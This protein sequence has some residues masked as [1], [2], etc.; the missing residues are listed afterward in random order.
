MKIVLSVVA[1]A[2]LA[3]NDA[4]IGAALGVLAA[5]W[6][7]IETEEGPPVIPLALT[8]QWFQVTA[9]LF[10]VAF[11]GRSLEATVRSDYRPMVWIGLGCVTA[12]LL[13][14][15]FGIRL[16]RRL[17]PVEGLRPEYAL[18]FKTLTLV[19]FVGTAVIGAVQR[20][21]WEIPSLTQP[22]IAL[23]YLRLGLLYLILRT[24]VRSSRW[25]LVAALLAL[26]IVLGITGFY[27]GFREPL[28]MAALA[29]L[30]I[31]DRR[32]V[33]H[34]MTAAALGTCMVALGVV[35]V[36]VRGDY[37]ERFLADET[38]ANS[39]SARIDNLSSAMRGWASR[40]SF[41]LGQD[42]DKFV[43]RMWA[44]Y[45]PAL[46][47]ARVPSTIPHT[48]GELMRNALIHVVMPRI[49]F[50]SKAS[51][52]SDSELVRRYAGVF[53]AGEQQ[54][55]SIAFGYAAESYVDFGVP[56]MFV[57]VLIYGV[58][59]GAAYAMLL[60]VLRHRDLAI[61]IVTVTFWLTLYLFERS[62][63]KTI[64]LAGTMMIYGGGIGIILDRLW[65]EK[66]RALHPLADEPADA[67]AQW[68]DRIA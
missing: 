4:L 57:P 9:G 43:E 3:S 19:Y 27:A 40:E 24:L 35:W 28:I 29:L 25:P 58:L 17:R 16:I 11:T 68:Q 52:E 47:L 53:V 51:L 63:V 14:I 45:Y 30:E 39:R 56:M 6:I 64:G 41:E 20:L 67:A 60:R 42:V 5:I 54:G 8:L 44:I 48:G 21:A 36:S 7:F 12:L 31:F 2:W 33:R 66:Y 38:F 62:W 65:Y 1:A 49:F 37:R 15:V 59:M 22:I 55:T 23:S 34:W 61:S 26:E 50:P 18:T 10:Y 13:G 46:A 32:S